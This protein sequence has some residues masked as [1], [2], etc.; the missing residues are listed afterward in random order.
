MTTMLLKSVSP[1]F[2]VSKVSRY[3][4]FFPGGIKHF[5]SASYN[6]S[7]TSYWKQIEV[8]NIVSF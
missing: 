6:L 8:W 5:Q 7:Y 3:G 4:F 2:N 1:I